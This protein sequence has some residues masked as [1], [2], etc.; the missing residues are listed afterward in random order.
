M[1]V[2]TFINLILIVATSFMCSKV[3]TMA[4]SSSSNSKKSHCIADGPL[5]KLIICLRDRNLIYVVQV[6]RVDDDDNMT[7]T[8]KAFYE[9]LVAGEE[10]A[11]KKLWAFQRVEIM[12]KILNEQILNRYNV[13]LEG[14]KRA[15]KDCVREY[16]FKPTIN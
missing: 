8:N 16:V 1:K 11:N 6:F 2:A 3:S 7:T 4:S 5:K 14:C 13:E 12:Q 9:A 15:I 10:E